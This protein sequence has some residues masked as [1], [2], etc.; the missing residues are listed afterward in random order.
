M[1]SIEITDTTPANM[2]RAIKAACD[3]LLGNSTQRVSGC[4]NKPDGTAV[5]LDEQAATHAGR[6]NELSAAAIVESEQAA[7]CLTALNAAQGTVLDLSTYEGSV[8]VQT[9]S[10]FHKLMEGSP[11]DLGGVTAAVVETV[12]VD[13]AGQPW[14]ADLHSSSRAKISDGT[15]KKRRNAAPPAPVQLPEGYGQVSHVPVAIEDAT[16]SQVAAVLPP[17]VPPLPPADTMKRIFALI[18]AQVCTLNE[19]LAAAAEHGIKDLG[20]NGLTGASAEVQ[21]A[22]LRK[23]E[24]N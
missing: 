10:S 7:R 13:S 21:L 16:A 1:I 23:L 18:T 12:E 17:P 24:G 20:Q 9:E 5:P 2:L 22:V 3:E 11:H 8:V 6:A 14:N 4:V 19:V 15:W